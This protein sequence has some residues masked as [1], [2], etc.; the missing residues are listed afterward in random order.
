ML[1]E[2]EALLAR[3][4]VSHCYLLFYEFAIEIQLDQGDWCAAE[5]YAGALE[6][7]MRAEPAPWGDFL[8][9]RARAL[10][11]AGGDTCDAPLAQT[12]RALADEARHAGI[13]WRLGKLEHA[14]QRV[15]GG[16]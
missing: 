8:I 6:A 15:A 1:A 16:A 3:G 14:L 7:Y 12:L 2:G 10:A 4:C 13:R 5:R 11:R 9:R